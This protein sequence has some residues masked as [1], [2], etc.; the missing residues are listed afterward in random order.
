MD[1]EDYLQLP[2]VQDYAFNFFTLEAWLKPVGDGVIVERQVEAG[3]YNYK[4]ELL[5]D[6]RLKLSFLEVGTNTIDGIRG[7]ARE[8]LFFS[9]DSRKSDLPKYFQIGPNSGDK[10][11]FQKVRISGEL[12]RINTIMIHTSHYAKKALSRLD[13]GINYISKERSYI[14][15]MQNRLESVIRNNENYAENISASESR[16]K[17]ADMAKEVMELIKNNIQQQATQAILAQAKQ[18]PEGVLSLLR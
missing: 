15:A 7:S 16:I 4:L 10:I 1:N 12:M 14:G 13:H 11:D 18:I 8:T 5:A 3:K 17:D 9:C 2:Q 6:G